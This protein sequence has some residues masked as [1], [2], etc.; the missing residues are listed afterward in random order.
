MIDIPTTSLAEDL[1][2]SKIITGPWQ[3]ADMER[4]GKE[5]DPDATARAMQPYLEAGLTTFDMADHYGSAEVISGRFRQQVG[6][7]R[8]QLLTKWVPESGKSSKEKVRAAV[9]RALDRM[10]VEQLDLLQYHAWNYADPA[11][12]D[13]LF[14]LRELREEGLIRHL[15]LTNFDERT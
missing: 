13:D 8:V 15:G 2:T 5:L 7:G 4:D 6:P 14:W 10:Q 1:Q 3:I 11:W 12:L 9:Q